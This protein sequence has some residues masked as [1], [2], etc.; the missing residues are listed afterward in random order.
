ML[1]QPQPNACEADRNGWFYALD[2]K[3]GK[4]IYAE[5]FVHSTSITGMKDG[6]PQS[7]P[8]YV[9]ALQ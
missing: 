2:R 4:L 1:Y 8:L 6:I 5:P 9:F 7:D 3:N